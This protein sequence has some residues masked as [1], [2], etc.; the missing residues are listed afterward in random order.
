MPRTLTLDEVLDLLRPGT[1]V[2]VPGMSGESL[3]L[4]AALEQ[5]PDA[6]SG[7]RFLGAQFPGIN[8]SDYVG[9]HPRARQRAYFMTPGLRAAMA[10]DRGEWLPL[11]YPGAWRDLTALDVDIAFAQVT[12]PDAQGRCSLGVSCDF[13]PAVW[14]RARQRIAHINPRMPR[15]AG[16][17]VI[18][19]ADLDAVFEVD[20][21]LLCWD[22]GT[23]GAEMQAHA[24]RVASL[25]RDGDTL[26]F[27]VGKLQAGILAALRNHRRLRVWSGMASTPLLGLLDADVVTGKASVNIGIALGDRPLYERCASDDRFFFRPVSETHDVRQLAAIE[28]FC[29][30]N[31]AVEVDLFGQVNADCVGGRL[32]AGV[33]GLPAFVAGA[34][35]S[36]G[37]RSIIALSAMT[38]DRRHSRIVARLSGPALAALPRHAADYV[39]TEH[40]VAALR[41]LDVAAR[42]RALIA[43]ADPSQREVLE[44]AWHDL[45]RAL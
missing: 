11:D 7:V 28:R 23:P 45:Q 41:G 1:N 22:G 9:L 42:A 37:G 30:I 2:F 35:L 34:S 3:A 17:F 16:S 8:R 4:Y 15:T 39:V 13:Q 27:G 40:G 21:E 5:R 20:H 10:E 31:S 36:P 43:V 6:A 29:A 32:V 38:D 33:G 26:E 18:R 25:V 44:R 14:S 19:Y 24:A 12:P